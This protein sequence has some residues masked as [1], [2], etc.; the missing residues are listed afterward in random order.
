[1]AG[2]R[3]LRGPDTDTWG[4]VLGSGPVGCPPISLSEGGCW[5]SGPGDSQIRKAQLPEK[6]SLLLRIQTA[7]LGGLGTDSSQATCSHL[8]GAPWTQLT[9]TPPPA[10][11]SCPAQHLWD[12]TGTGDHDFST[13]HHGHSGWSCAWV[14]LRGQMGFPGQGPP[15]L[16]F[17]LPL[18]FPFPSLSSPHISP[19]P[20]PPM[21]GLSRN[22][23]TPR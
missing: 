11:L 1:M 12:Q 4:S 15:L 20:F 6:A 5:G 18:P 21:P 9:P 14:G 16:P 13:S 7:Y 23:G 22:L 3:V 8:T 19:L 2:G 17:H 10:W